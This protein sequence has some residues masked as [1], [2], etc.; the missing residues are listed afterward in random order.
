MREYKYV[1]ERT[2][3]GRGRHAPRRPW[4]H[5]RAAMDPPVVSVHA[6]RVRHPPGVPRAGLVPR[7]S[8]DSLSAPAAIA[9]SSGA[10]SRPT[11]TREAPDGRRYWRSRFEI[12]RGC[13]RYRRSPRRDE[14]AHAIR[15]GTDDWAPNGS[16]YTSRG[17][18]GDGGQAPSSSPKATR[19][20]WDAAPAS[21]T[22]RPG[23]RS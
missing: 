22:P 21:R 10:T 15:T 23:R 8:H 20:V 12:D 1:D 13:R 19:R 17:S 16:G 14:G 18:D 11:D 9:P 5:R 4:S 6:P 7:R 2:L 3:R